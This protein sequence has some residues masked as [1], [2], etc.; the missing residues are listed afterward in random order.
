[1]C[2][3]PQTGTLFGADNRI[4]AIVTLVPQN[5]GAGAAAPPAGERLGPA[6]ETAPMRQTPYTLRRDFLLDPETRLPRSKPPWGV[7]VALDLKAGKLKWEV[8][9]GSVSQD[10]IHP[11]QEKWGSVSLGGPVCTAGGVVFVAGTLDAHL[12]AFDSRTG[13]VLWKAPLPAGGQATPM[14]Y[15]YAGRQYVVIAA[16]GHGKLGSKLGDYVI[17]FA[18]P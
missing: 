16:G 18:L 15:E 3:D 12:R 2:Y 7:L 1:M 8:P 17:A 5:E 9:L 6:G 13:D 14:T 4:A 10:P 11:D